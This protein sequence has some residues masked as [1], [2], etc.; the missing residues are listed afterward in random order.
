LI[1]NVSGSLLLGAG[2]LGGYTT[3]STFAV[4]LD[5]LISAHRPMTAAQYVLVTV[6]G[7]A[8]AVWAATVVTQ[9][10]TEAVIAARV[11]RRLQRSER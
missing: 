10:S 3:F 7:C 6:F 11:R 2:V 4:D 8:V 9:R 5:R 1:I